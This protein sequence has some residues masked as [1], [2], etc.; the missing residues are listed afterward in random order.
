MAELLDDTKSEELERKI[1]SK[2][3]IRGLLIGINLLLVAYLCYA[4]TD[5]II[6]LVNDNKDTGNYVT[7][8]GKSEKGSKKIYE[9]Y[10]SDTID[11]DFMAFDDNIILSNGIYDSGENKS[12]SNVQLFNVCSLNGPIHSS[13]RYDGMGNYVN[14]GI[15]LF[16]NNKK[17]DYLEEGD[18]IFY[19]DYVDAEHRGKVVNV[20][21]KRNIKQTFYS[22][23]NLDGIRV[24]STLYAYE[25]NKALILNVT[26]VDNIP[27][28]YYDVVVKGEGE[29][30]TNASSKLQELGLKVKISNETKE[31]K[32]FN[33]HSPRI[34]NFMNGNIEKVSCNT[35]INNGLEKE[36]NDFNSQMLGY[37][38]SNGTYNEFYSDHHVG[39]FVIDVTYIDSSTVSLISFI[40][41]LF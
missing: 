38:L 19:S 33:I 31:E 4:V 14:D 6:S 30:V 34:L 2:T 9:Q 35:R 1:K 7:I 21:A 29:L 18:Y 15:S 27:E 23:P 10:I 36:N 26:Y 8:C 17:D 13:Y 41:E 40:D 11:G 25:N 32:Y 28:D 22:L 5:S 37:A 39:K 20:N 3:R 24:K 12:F 16:Y